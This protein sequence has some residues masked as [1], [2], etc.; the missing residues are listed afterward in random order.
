MELLKDLPFNAQPGDPLGQDP[1]I[2]TLVNT[3]QRIPTPACIA[4]YGSWG[5]GKSTVLHSAAKRWKNDK[6]GPVV[7]F[8]PW[9][10]ERQDDLLTPFLFH[11]VD[12]LGLSGARL[13]RAKALAGSIL[14]VLVSLT[15]RVGLAYATAGISEVAKAAAAPFDKFKPED[16]AQYFTEHKEYQDAVKS[17]KL[18]FAELVALG[19]EEFRAT[20]Q[21]LP[22]GSDP[23]VAIYIDDVDRCLPDNVVALIEGI[24]LLLAGDGVT[25]QLVA[26]ESKKAS[27]KAVFVFAL[28]RQIVGEAIRARYPNSTLYTGENYLEKIFD[29]SLEVPPA[30]ADGIKQLITDCLQDGDRLNRLTKP[31]ESTENGLELLVGV[32][33]QP[34]FANPRVI[35]RVLNR[36]DLLFADD[37][38]RSKVAGIRDAKLAKRFVAWAAGAERFRT[39]RHFYFAATQVEIAAMGRAILGMGEEAGLTPA[40]SQLLDTPGFW[41]YSILLWGL[42]DSLYLEDFEKQRELSPDGA[43]KTLRDFD[44]LLRSAGL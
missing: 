37:E 41:N 6:L 9:E 2:R 28:D 27:N 30:R 34:V 35:K 16:F 1:A 7:W 40:V 10:Y 22:S 18:R 33:S 19:I 42:L 4:L 14:K 36:L 21:E 39:F 44:D 11:I 8:D 13:E 43:L 38:R 26:D 15:A 32:L 12:Q 20:N 24:K 31:F 25:P 29:V 5:A 3:L 17:T 23:R